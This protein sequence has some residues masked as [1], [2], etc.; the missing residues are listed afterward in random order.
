MTSVRERRQVLRDVVGALGPLDD[1][2]T[3]DT[4]Q[5][6]PNLMVEY[7]RRTILIGAVAI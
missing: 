3:A 7:P 4:K 1:T 5:D 6:R 2:Y